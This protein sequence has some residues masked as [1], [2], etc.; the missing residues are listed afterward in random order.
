M[1]QPTDEAPDADRPVPPPPAD[2]RASPA[3]LRDVA[4][5]AGVSVALVSY[6]LNG[7]GRVSATTEARIL[8]IAD[9]LGYRAN[10]LARAL[11]TGR[12][13]TIGVIIRNLRNPLFADVLSAMEDEA[14]VQG[15]ALTIRNS[16]YDLEDQQRLLDSLVDDGVRAIVIAPVGTGDE[17]TAW[18]RQHAHIPLVALNMSMPRTTSLSTINPDHQEAVRLAVEHLAARGHRTITFVAAPRHLAADLTREIAFVEQC[19]RLGVTPRTLRTKLTVEAVQRAVAADLADRDRRE[20]PAF[21]LNSDHLAAGVYHAARG[22]D[23]EL[24]HDL[25]V[26]GHDDLPSSDLLAPGLTT[27]AFDRDQLGRD[28]VRLALSPGSQEH[29]ALPVRLVVR[30]S[31]R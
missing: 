2:R 24:G 26:V 15:L 13:S 3:T 25:S 14:R 6:A 1:S 23:L 12:Y 21:L 19:A 8:Q 27:I 16:R 18:Q 5:A 30:E 9:Q 20:A 22:A 29:I 31:V 10:R 17:L 28:A 11:R 7:T 4:A